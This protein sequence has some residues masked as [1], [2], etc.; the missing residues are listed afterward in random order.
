VSE[1][2]TDACVRPLLARPAA[3][4][5]LMR[6]RTV[7]R[8]NNRA[9]HIPSFM[10][11]DRQTDRHTDR[12]TYRHTDTQT[13]RQTDRQTDRYLTPFLSLARSMVHLLIVA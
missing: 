4:G 13:G 11:T 9:L 6:A 10:R 8:T 12:Q 2:R 7:A 3:Y 1:K 5:Q